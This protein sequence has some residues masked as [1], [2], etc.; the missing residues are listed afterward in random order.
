MEQYH[1]NEKE[2]QRG[3]EDVLSFCIEEGQFT[4]DG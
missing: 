2:D 4:R 3:L 1:N